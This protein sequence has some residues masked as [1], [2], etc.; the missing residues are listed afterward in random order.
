MNRKVLDP[1][2][3]MS[4]LTA[5][6]FVYKSAEIELGEKPILKKKLELSQLQVQK[7]IAERQ[8]V[9]LDFANYKYIK[10]KAD[11]GGRQPASIRKTT[12]IDFSPVLLKRAQVAFS[13]S[14]EDVA[15]EALRELFSR[16]PSSPDLAE[17]LLLE[18]EIR[19]QKGDLV[20]SLDSLMILV[21]NHSGKLEAG[22]GLLKIASI[23]KDQRRF[24]EAS[25][26]LAILEAQFSDSS[27]LVTKAKDL[28]RSLQ[29][30]PNSDL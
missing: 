3:L 16:Y 26:V 28:S 22:Y 1:I 13:E 15:L 18:A 27:S 12:G 24:E 10:E 4:I 5:L 14:K 6:L 8:K 25:S 11:D 30:R 9:I 29:M 20:S 23:Y 2:I 21:E 19:S 7:E 17:A